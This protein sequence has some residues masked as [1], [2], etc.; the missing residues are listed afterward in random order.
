MKTSLTLLAALISAATFG[1][2][3]ATLLNTP[4]T[5][6]PFD[7]IANAPGGTLLNSIVSP[8]LAPTFNGTIRTAVYDGPEPGTNLD[9]YYQFTNGQSSDDAVVR[10]TTRDFRGFL[11]DV[12]QTATGFGSFINGQTQADAA[13]RSANGAVVGFNWLQGGPNTLDQG[14]TSY[15][16]L[17]RT[18]AELFD[19]GTIG[20]IDGSGTTTI[21]FAPVIPEPETYALMLAGLGLLGFAKRRN[22]KK[23]KTRLTEGLSSKLAAA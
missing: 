6:T 17:V 7:V 2:A 22:L 1:S 19:F 13:D 23:A 5:L 10:L 4:Q 8:V 21:G 18:N 14:E 9:F 16:L 12:Y 3:H 20:L 15:T 11:T